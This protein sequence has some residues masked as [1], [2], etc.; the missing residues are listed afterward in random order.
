MLYTTT[1][2]TYVV[3]VSVCSDISRNDPFDAGMLL[4][5]MCSNVVFWN[6]LYES[7]IVLINSNMTTILSI[8]LQ[9][10]E[11]TS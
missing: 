8:Q 6:S 10:F 1:Q 11:C 9:F 2:C 3:S 5:L 4:K 7:Y